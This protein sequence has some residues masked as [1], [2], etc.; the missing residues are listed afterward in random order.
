VLDDLRVVPEPA[1]ASGIR[2]AKA[3][4]DDIAETLEALISAHRQLKAD[5]PHWQAAAAA[6]AITLETEIAALIKPEADC[7]GSPFEGGARAAAALVGFAFQRRGADSARR[8]L[9]RRRSV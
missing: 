5:L 2:R 4:R 8:Q 9:Y 6:A 7:A 1:I 3:V